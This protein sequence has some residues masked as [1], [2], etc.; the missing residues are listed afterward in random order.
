MARRPN[1]AFEKRQ[2]ELEKKAKKEARR[3]KKGD[4]RAAAKKADLGEGVGG[5]HEVT[6]ESDSEA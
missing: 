5:E 6:I 2:K 4:R 3:A 1:Y